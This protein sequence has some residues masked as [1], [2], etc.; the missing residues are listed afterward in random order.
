MLDSLDFG[1]DTLEDS[2]RL[3]ERDQCAILRFSVNRRSNADVLVK[4]W[5]FLLLC[6]T[7]ASCSLLGL[8]DP[9]WDTDVPESAPVRA[10][11]GTWGPEGERIAFIHTPD[12]ADVTAPF[13]QLWTYHLEADTMRR[14]LKGPLLTPNWSPSGNRFVFHSD[15]LPQHLFT[16]SATGDSLN[17]LT[18]PNSP[19]PDLENTVIGKWSPTGNRLLFSVEAGEKSGIYTMTP[20]GSEVTK[21]VGWS[22]QPAWF[23]S[24]ERIVYI[25][26]DSSDDRQVFV[27]GAN[28]DDQRK[29]TNLDNSE[30][31]G[32]PS[33]SPDGEQIAFAYDDQIYLMSAT[34]ENVRQVTGGKGTAQQPV[35]SPNGETILFWRRF[36]DSSQ[37]PER[38]YF[39]DV[40]T[41]EVEPVFPASGT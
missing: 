1:E 21:V 15:Q 20:D 11:L 29:L 34:G 37:T 28:G 2:D 25:D 7:L 24:G 5:P 10:L 13:N 39:L 41:L 9:R 8:D 32:W 35:W 33:V 40:E 30:S 16:A 36:F 27:I 26:F 19:N 3:S 23:P 22:V 12:T 17:K 31:L 38:M 14:V 4:Y 6:I 18:G